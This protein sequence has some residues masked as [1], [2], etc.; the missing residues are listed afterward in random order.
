MAKRRF[1]LI[2][3]KSVI[4]TNLFTSHKFY[5]IVFGVENV[6]TC[7]IYRYIPRDEKEFTLS[8]LCKN[9]FDFCSLQQE[10]LAVTVSARLENCEAAAAGAHGGNM[11]N[12][13]KS[14]AVNSLT[15][16]DIQYFF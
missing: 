16:E 14:V 8:S 5:F 9:W 12:F 4:F 2:K 11:E 6:Y 10:L 1:G 13:S 15:L 3:L 7:S